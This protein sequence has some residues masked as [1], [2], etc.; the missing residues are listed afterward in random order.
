[1]NDYSLASSVGLGVLLLLI[2]NV[3]SVIQGVYLLYI[4]SFIDRYIEDPGLSETMFINVTI[5][6]VVLRCIRNLFFVA[7]LYKR[8]FCYWKAVVATWASV[9]LLQLGSSVW[10][11][12]SLDKGPD[13]IIVKAI[14]WIALIFFDM[15]RLPESYPLRQELTAALK[16]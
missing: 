8:Y 1:M 12:L 5:A 3:G 2:S 13:E 14:V 15:V 10:L 16:E 4:L 6:E 7:Q 9:S 11:Y